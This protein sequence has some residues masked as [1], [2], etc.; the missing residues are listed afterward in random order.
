MIAFFHT[1]PKANNSRTTAAV[2]NIAS[3]SSITT[4]LENA[5][6]S[7]SAAQ[8]AAAGYEYAQNK[9]GDK[10]NQ[11]TIAVVDFTKPSD[12]KRLYVVNLKDGDLIGQY[13]VAHGSNSGGLYARHFSNAPDSHESSLGVFAVGATYYG[14]HGKSRHMIGLEKGINN[15]AV[16]RDVELHRAN[17]VLPSYI[18]RNHTA[19]RTWGCFGINPNKADTIINELPAN[20]VLFAYA[21]QENN[22]VNLISS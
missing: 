10:L 9:K 15:N 21:H 8:K 16:R 14:K 4:L 13:F 22:D 2:R 19:G 17:Y 1:T 18:K 7:D 12:Q 5:G 20:T 11:S 3:Q 6:V